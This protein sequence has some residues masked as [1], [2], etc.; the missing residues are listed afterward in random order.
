MFIWYNNYLSH[1]F[2]D[3][4]W[5]L[6]KHRHL[7]FCVLLHG[8]GEWSRCRWYCRTGA[9]NSTKLNHH[10]ATEDGCRESEGHRSFGVEGVLLE[11]HLVEGGQ[12][13]Q[14]N[15]NQIYYTNHE[16]SETEEV[17]ATFILRFKRSVPG[18]LAE[19]L[20]GLLRGQLDSP[21]SSH[22][23][24]HPVSARHHQMSSVLPIGGRRWLPSQCLCLR[25]V[26]PSRCNRIAS[27]TAQW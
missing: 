1:K 11:L 10:R 14:Y 18:T 16:G 9:R 8:L 22:W 13:H 23:S 17:A 3:Y 2:L 4:L 21:H 25:I 6:I 24:L 26:L 15:N 7:W 20:L 5:I 12:V 27:S 19:L